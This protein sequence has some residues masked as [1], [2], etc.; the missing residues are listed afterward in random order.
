V[1]SVLRE[2]W[3]KCCGDRKEKDIDS[4]S[5]NLGGLHRDDGTEV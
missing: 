2:V 1:K 5:R 4:A 3:R